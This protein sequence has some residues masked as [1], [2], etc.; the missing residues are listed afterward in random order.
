MVCWEE[1]VS[2]L[3]GRGQPAQTHWPRSPLGPLT[4][5]SLMP[6]RQAVGSSRLRSSPSRMDE[7]LSEFR[8]K[9]SVSAS[10]T[11]R[12]R[13]SLRPQG[14]AGAGQ[15]FQKDAGHWLQRPRDPA[16]WAGAG[17]D[18]AVS[19]SAEAPARAGPEGRQAVVGCEPQSRLLAPR[20]VTI[21]A[22]RCGPSRPS[23]V[24]A[25]HWGS[26]LG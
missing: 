20:P 24:S 1:A 2:W 19:Q 5:L 26:F 18:T 4:L 7:D 6:G 12:E 14:W 22:G 8:E 9:A 15:L 11:C 16:S 17:D 23:R 25:C 3:G 13:W 10:C 21:Q